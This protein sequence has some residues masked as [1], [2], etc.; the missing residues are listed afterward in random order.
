MGEPADAASSFDFTA[1]AFL[2][3]GPANA[4]AAR[5]GWAAEAWLM[6]ERIVIAHRP[7]F[8]P[9]PRDL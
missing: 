5:Q 2:L 8:G 4:Q 6:M 1:V 3:S 7:H 9:H